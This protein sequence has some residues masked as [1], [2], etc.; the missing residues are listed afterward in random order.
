MQETY[1]N[2]GLLW[3]EVDCGDMGKHK[4]SDKELEAIMF[5]DKKNIR[6]VRL[7]DL[8]INVAFVRGAIRNYV[9][10]S[11]LEYTSENDIDKRF[12]IDEDSNKLIEK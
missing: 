6:F 1:K 7:K 12:L 3:W 10:S 8:V 5:A 2:K 11:A 9:P 4:L